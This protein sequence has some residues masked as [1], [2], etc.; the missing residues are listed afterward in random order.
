MARTL[1]VTWDGGG[2]VG[3]A[4]EIAKELRD[5][6]DKVRFI[7]QRQQ[8]A[9]FDELGFGFSEYTNPGPWTATGKRNA[10]TNAVG[11]LRLLAGRSLGRD[12]MLEVRTHPT[13]LV[14]VDCLLYGALS[15]AGRT[16]LPYAVLVHSLF[17]AVEKNMAGGAP[18]AVARLVGLNPWRLWAAADGRVAVTLE[19]FDVPPS[20]P[21]ALTYTGP[22]VPALGQR[23]ASGGTVLV[24]LSTTY[25]AG[26]ARVLQNILDALADLPISVLAT[27]GPAVDPSELRVPANAKAHRY[28]PH[29]QIIGDVSLVVGHGG[30]S[31]TMLAL[32]QGVPLVVIPMNPAFDQ[33]MIGRRVQEQGA[34]LTLPSNSSSA[35]IREAVDRVLRGESFH[36]AAERLGALIGNTGGTTAAAVA[37]QALRSH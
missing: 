19:E 26:Q 24:S 2:N 5:R 10:V 18:G 9:A 33:P 30:H 13:D 20:N 36:R 11:F 12:L 15:A 8:R 25:I 32:A 37:L 31:T 1:F 6:G 16:G 35:E 7:G 34:G 17:A 29:A 23:S 14:V 28:I 22:I 3:P 27:T 21:L 4:V